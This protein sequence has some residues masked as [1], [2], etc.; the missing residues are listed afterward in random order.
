MEELQE[1]EES[2]LYDLWGIFFVLG[3]SIY[4]YSKDYKNLFLLKNI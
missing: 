1:E 4:I 3:F 2:G